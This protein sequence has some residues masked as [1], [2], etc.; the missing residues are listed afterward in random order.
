VTVDGVVGG[1]KK[2]SPFVDTLLLWQQAVA[3]SEKNF[4]KL[5]PWLHQQFLKKKSPKSILFRFSEF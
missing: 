2:F 5:A 4:R 1:H 3:Q